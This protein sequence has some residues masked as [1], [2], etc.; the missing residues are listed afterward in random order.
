[1]PARISRDRGSVTIASGVEPQ[2]ASGLT[3]LDV[4]MPQT[5]SLYRFTAPRG[6]ATITVRAV[7]NQSISMAKRLGLTAVVVLLAWALWRFG[8]PLLE[9]AAAHQKTGLVLAIVGLLSLL[10]GVLPLA[11][12]VLLVIGLVLR[13]QGRE[14]K[15]PVTAAA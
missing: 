14:R 4:E 2:L 15:Q 13:F 8:W 6:D 3:S 9:R 12:A 7:S 10:T 5:G 11:G 1:M